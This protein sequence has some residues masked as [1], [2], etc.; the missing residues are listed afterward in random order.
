MPNQDERYKLKI[1]VDELDE[2]RDLAPN[3]ANRLEPC[4]YPN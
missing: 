1:N 2:M 4:C 3:D